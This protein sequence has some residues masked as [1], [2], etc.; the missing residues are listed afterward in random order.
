LTRLNVKLTLIALGVVMIGLGAYLNSILEIDL[1]KLDNPVSNP[2]MGSSVILI[3]G[4]T[5]MTIIGATLPYQVRVARPSRYTT[6]NIVVQP[7]YVPVATSQQP[8]TY[9]RPSQIQQQKMMKPCPRCGMPVPIYS[10]FC[11]NC[12]AKLV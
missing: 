2:Y 9:T 5:F 1:T 6:E 12:G 11:P 7:A 10:R 8:A 4:G 3:I